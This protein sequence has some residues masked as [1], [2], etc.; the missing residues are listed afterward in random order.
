MLIYSLIP[1]RSGSKR[2]KHKN[3]LIFRGKTL[4][5]LAIE[6]SLQTKK[7]ER[8]F[9]S[10]DSKKYQNLSIEAGA[11]CPYLRPKKISQDRSTDLECFKHFL[12]KL[13]ELNIKK[14]DV[15]VHLRPTYPIRSAELISLC[16]NKFLSKKKI[17]SL[18]TVIKIKHNMQKMWFMDKNKMLYNS[19]TSNNEQ[20]SLP[21]QNLNKTYLQTNC[22]DII[23]VRNTLEKNSMIGKRIYGFETSNDFDI[24]DLE[25]FKRINQN[26]KT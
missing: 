15:I 14:P 16:I 20:H 21:Y 3:I 18:R 8:T 26:F 2:I 12:I 25:D 11:E 10:T 5:E 4:L 6:Q 13:R 24:D 23:S 7:I 19:I 22:I 1:A 17:H 9:V